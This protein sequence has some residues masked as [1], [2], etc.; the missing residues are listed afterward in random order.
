[1]K[2]LLLKYNK[3]TNQSFDVL[4]RHPAI[5]FFVSDLGKFGGKMD[6]LSV[7]NV[8]KIIPDNVD[9]IVVG[10]IFWPTGQNIC[11]YAEQRGIKV[12]FLQHG[13]WIYIDN[14]RNPRHLPFCTLVN[15]ERT[16][17]MVMQWPYA[18]RSKVHAVGNPRYDE[19]HRQS[20]GDFVYFGPPVLTEI[21][22]SGASRR[23]E[24]AAV[25]LTNLKGIDKRVKIKIH[26][27]Y[28]E[29]RVSVLK[30]MFPQAE[31]I[32]PKD[33]PLKHVSQSSKVLTHRNSTAVIDAIA[34]GKPSVFVDFRGQ[35]RS[36]FKRGHFGP[37]GI[38]CDSPIDCISKVS[39]NTKLPFDVNSAEYSVAAAAY[40]Q[41]GNA[42]ERI[43]KLMQGYNA[44]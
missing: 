33:D 19:I 30:E 36:F 41:V 15:G 23:N 44:T 7:A 31:I 16:L 21:E 22:H 42:S 5:D 25:L 39:A 28:R 2:V 10:D 3:V 12:Y 29:G 27:H 14:K 11:R 17:Q 35:D 24:N 20:E 1:M 38:E 34:C 18:N 37:F 40:L 43:V 13:Q 32:D 6:H 9:A 4:S 26:P 8:Q